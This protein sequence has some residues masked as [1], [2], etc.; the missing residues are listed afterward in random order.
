MPSWIPAA[1]ASIGAIGQQVIAGGQTRR[2]IRDQHKRD[3]GLSA[4]KHE[5][6]MKQIKYMNQYNAPKQQ[7]ER[8]R[9][10]G[11]N[12]NLMY[13]QGDP[14]QQ[15]QIA[16]YNQPPS[17]F[18]KRQPMVN[19]PSIISA[20][21]DY[22]IKEAQADQARAVADVEQMKA[23]G[24]GRKQITMKSDGKTIPL[25]PGKIGEAQAQAR[26]WKDIQEV[27]RFLPEK[28]R[29]GRAEADSAE[30]RAM[31]DK[32][33]ND[34]AQEGFNFDRDNPYVRMIAKMLM[35]SDLF[36]IS[37]RDRELLFEG[38]SRREQ[39][40]QRNRRFNPPWMK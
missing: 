7:M 19:I 38:P 23:S 13:S 25:L 10:A 33:R 1:L 39:E 5:L 24:L 30:F 12:P 34:F 32:V 14:G 31:I 28:I 4:F 40:F 20:Y 16:E 35:Q 3:L 11:L 2:N 8:F 37:E 21:Q 6:D 22:R 18:S 29:K 36:D 26:G 27:Q 15:T 9:E 17:D